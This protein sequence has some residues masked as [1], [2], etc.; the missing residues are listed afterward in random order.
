[1]YKES[2]MW[3]KKLAILIEQLIYDTIL[4]SI[5][6]IF[7]VGY[8]NKISLQLGNTNHQNYCPN[9]VKHRFRRE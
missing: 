2:S 1:M 6:L 3:M 9:G 5:S 7:N 8:L 4:L